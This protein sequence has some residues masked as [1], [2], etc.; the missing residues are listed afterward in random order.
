MK[1]KRIKVAYVTKWAAT[2]G[3]VVVKGM[4]MTGN[5]YLY[6]GFTSVPEREWTED[7]SVAEARWRNAVGRA[8]DAAQRKADA[9]RAQLSGPAK[10]EEST[11]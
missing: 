4:E 7:K 2:R 11:P 6:T 5:G 10:Y 8:A 3:I 9:L 1:H